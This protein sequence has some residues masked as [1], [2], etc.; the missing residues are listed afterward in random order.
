[1]SARARA[2]RQVD[3]HGGIRADVGSVVRSVEAEEL[4]CAG[5]TGQ[6]IIASKTAKTIR[7]GITV[8]R[9]VA[10]VA[11]K[12]VG[13]NISDD[14]VGAWAADHVLHA[15]QRVAI[16]S[17]AGGQVDGHP[18]RVAIPDSSMPA[19]PS[20]MSAPSPPSKMLV[21]VPRP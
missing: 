3:G 13:I 6:D 7:P 20:M 8:E 16:R 11:E 2:E 19:P 10:R 5:A 15:G 4:V 18:R 17:G 1:M 21:T 14:A 9:I 12:R